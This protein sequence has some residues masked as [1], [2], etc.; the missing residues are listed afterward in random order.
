MG[1]LGTVLHKRDITLLNCQNTSHQLIV[2]YEDS[3]LQYAKGK[4]LYLF[5]FAL[6]VYFVCHTFLFLLLNPLFEKY[7]TKYKLCSYW[8][9]IKPLLDAYSG[10]M[11]DEYRFWPGLLLVARIPILLAVTFVEN[12]IQFH[13]LLLSININVSTICNMVNDLL[14]ST[15]IQQSSSQLYGNMIYFHAE[16]GSTSYGF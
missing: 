2:W 1:S 13:S 3:T 5:S 11:K 8:Y 12:L 6:I 9:K 4:H 10:P 7:L 14:L 15:G 16:Y